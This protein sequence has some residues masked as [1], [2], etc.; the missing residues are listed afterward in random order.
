MVER[1]RNSLRVLNEGLLEKVSFNTLKQVI[2]LSLKDNHLL[3]CR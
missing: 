1:C 3:Y 2:F